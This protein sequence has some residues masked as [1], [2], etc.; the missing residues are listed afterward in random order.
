MLNRRVT[1]S[2]LFLFVFSIPPLLRSE[3]R[4]VEFHARREFN[5]AVLEWA[6]EKEE[7]LQKFVIQR[8]TDNMNWTT[9]DEVKPQPGEFTSKRTY[10]YIDKSIFK[11]S[12]STFYYRLLIV[13]KNGQSTPHSV[14]VSISGNSGIKHTWGSIKAM[15]R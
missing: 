13:N 3:T 2:L 11:N 7:D 1:L 8:S 4:I 9:I 6:T 15:F 5:Y 12:I 14:I 10:T